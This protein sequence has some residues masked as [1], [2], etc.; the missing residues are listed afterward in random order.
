MN[1][2]SRCTVHYGKVFPVLSRIAEHVT[3]TILQDQF[4]IQTFINVY[5]SFL[6][7]C[8]YV[9]IIMIY[10]THISSW[11]LRQVVAVPNWLDLFI[12]WSPPIHVIVEVS[13]CRSSFQSCVTS[14]VMSQQSHV[15]CMI[16]TSPPETIRVRVITYSDY[17][18]REY[19]INPFPALIGKIY[20]ADRASCVPMKVD[21]TGLWNSYFQLGWPTIV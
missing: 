11:K 18:F 12:F 14:H 7:V 15:L 21:L 16:I 2:H 3:H 5:F 10:H 8:R 20:A 13:S 6:P 19:K 1:R 17:F 9:G 4:I